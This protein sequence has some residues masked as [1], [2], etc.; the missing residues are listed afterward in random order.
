MDY[1][2]NG[3]SGI[4]QSSNQMLLKS[5]DS[6]FRRAMDLVV[7]SLGLI[8]L[9][10]VFLWVA[11]RIKRDSPGPVFYQGL[12]AGK[13]G[14]PIKILKFRTMYED[15]A[16]YR[17]SEVTAQDDER[18]TPL[19]KFLRDSKLNEIP[20]LWNVLRGDMSLVGPRPEAITIASLWP[21]DVREVILSVRPGITSPASVLYRSEEQLLNH[22]NVME[23]YVRSILPSKLRLD[24]LYVRNHSVLTDIDIIFWTAVALLPALRNHKIAEPRLFWGPLALFVTRFMSWF[25]IDTLVVFGSALMAELIWRTSIPI[26]LGYTNAVL[27]ALLIGV[28]FSL[29][30]ALFGLNRVTWSRAAAT[31]ALMLGL[32]AAISSGIL[33]ILKLNFL[34]DAVLPVGL[35]ITAGLLSF[36]GFVL[37][38]YRER[39]ITGAATR[40]IHLRA[41]KRTLAER[42]LIIGAG[43]NGELAIW[44]F[45]RP[46]LSA[47]FTVIGVVDDDPRKRGMRINGIPVLGSS[48]N[49]LDIVK[50]NDI[51]LI[52]Y[53]IY[54]I[55][56][57]ERYRLIRNCAKTTARLVILPD[58]MS[59]FFDGSHPLSASLDISSK[60]LTIHERRR[61]LEKIEDLARAGDLDGILNLT[62]TYKIILEKEEANRN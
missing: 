52:V 5:V 22:K 29:I 31:D 4:K 7:A 8:C 51:G 39:L 38:R 60:P 15:E 62:S 61:Y 44:L 18:I 12:R 34:E 13:N 45:N 24:L 37:V 3:I 23:E 16:S 53:T 59:Q 14:K 43:D 2:Y 19:G 35:L 10:P 54:N 26:N 36:F 55:S 58:V 32:S 25:L 48:E 33:V 57:Q 28:F 17:G 11:I 47:A 56:A 42:V 27:V 41:G 46:R 20:Q 1:S 50:Q 21:E 6:F 30:N 9:S 49:L 40:W